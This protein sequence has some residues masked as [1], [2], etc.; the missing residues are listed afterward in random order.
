VLER[1]AHTLP[2]RFVVSMKITARVGCYRQVAYT[3]RKARY[4]RALALTR[5]GRFRAVASLEFGAVL[6]P[7]RSDDVYQSIRAQH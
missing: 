1:A 4:H 2:R 5:A 7:R 6:K 3:L